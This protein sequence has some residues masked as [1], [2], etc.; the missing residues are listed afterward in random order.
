MSTFVRVRYNCVCVCLCVC[1]YVSACMCAS[2]HAYCQVGLS[3][4]AGIIVGLEFV[5]LLIFLVSFFIS[6]FLRLNALV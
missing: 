3:C 4:P 6:G 2:L 1:L 5:S